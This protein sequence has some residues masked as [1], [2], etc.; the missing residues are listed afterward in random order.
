MVLSV[1]FPRVGDGVVG[2]LQS[3]NHER[4]VN[5]LVSTAKCLVNPVSDC[6]QQRKSRTLSNWLVPTA[7]CLVNPVSD[8]IQQRKS[9]NLSNRLQSIR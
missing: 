2:C 6:I 9:R 7:K 8:C 5:W 3:E 1:L 4:L